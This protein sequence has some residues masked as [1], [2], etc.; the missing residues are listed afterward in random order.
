MRFLLPLL[1]L[2]SGH[3]EADLLRRES[4]LDLSLWTQGLEAGPNQSLQVSIAL[5]I[6]NAHVGAE[7]LLRISDPASPEYG[8]HLSVKDV[9]RMFEP[10]PSAVSDVVKWLEESG[11]DKNHVNLS[12]GSDRLLLSLSVQEAALL[13]ET[14]FYHQTHQVTGQERIFCQHYHIPKPLAGHIDY[15]LAASSPP[16]AHRQTPRHTH[17]QQVGLNQEQ[18]VASSAPLPSNCFQQTSLSC[19]RNLYKIPQNVPP[20]PNNSFGIF[21]PSWISWLPEDLDQFFGKMQPDRVGHRPKVDGVNGGYWQRNYTMPM[22]NLEP[23]LDFEYAMALTS[24]QEVTNVEVGSDTDVG[25]L[26]DMLAAFDEYYCDPVPSKDRKYPDFY[27]PGCNNTACDCGS[28][29]PPKVLSI[30]WGWTEAGFSANYLQR[31]CLEFLKLGLMGTTVVVSV[32]DH[33]TA[34]GGGHFCIDDD[35]TGNG[36]TAKKFSPVFPASCPWVTSVGGT[37]MGS[38]AT[39]NEETAWRRVLDKKL[40]TSGGG[41][42]NVFSAPPYQVP[43]VARYKDLEKNHL[44]A[45]RD[46]FS[47]TG[48]GYPDVAVRAD[49]YNVVSN[50]KWE[51]VSGTSASNPVFASIITLINSE[52]MNAGK[53]P[54]GFINPVLYGSPDVLNDVVTGANEGCGAD[55]A[56]RAARGWDAVTGLGSPDYERMRRLFMSLP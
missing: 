26:H 4:S 24:P 10:E 52:R 22:F 42:S 9:A 8:Q 23:N 5:T 46:R 3:A 34:S 53:G 16:M 2:V 55:P 38:N 6:Q 37:Q 56:F 35:P 27:M 31:Q 7:T 14:T 15:I 48:R 25:N 40:A 1:L 41:F 32:S 19:L 17:Q 12:H 47:S 36:T 49:E 11:I 43:N 39:T 18:S 44:D 51:R 20:H 21:E 13:L 29:S 30:S 28:L 50:G 54:V 45:V 33:G